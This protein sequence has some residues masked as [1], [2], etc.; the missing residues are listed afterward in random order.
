MST[1][2]SLLKL[3]VYKKPSNRETTIAANVKT[4]T[5]QNR[6][7]IKYRMFKTTKLHYFEMLLFKLYINYLVKKKI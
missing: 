2:I 7:N 5:L 1:E 4:D 6:Y 3:Q